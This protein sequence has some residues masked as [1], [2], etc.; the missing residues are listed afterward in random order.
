MHPASASPPIEFAYSLGAIQKS[1]E[2]I[3]DSGNTIVKVDPF[4]GV[5][6]IRSSP[7]LRLRT[8]FT[9]ASP[10]PVPPVSRERPL[11]TR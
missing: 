4:P 8:C 9:M 6:S 10:S 1:S 11:S 2:K 5:D 7:P 3:L